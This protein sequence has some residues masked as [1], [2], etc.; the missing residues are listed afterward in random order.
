M[1][2]N[3]DKINNN[4]TE[5][6][7]LDETAKEISFALD[8]VTKSLNNPFISKVYETNQ[9]IWFSSV[10]AEEGGKK[11]MAVGI[12]SKKVSKGMIISIHNTSIY[13]GEYLV[14]ENTGSSIIFENEAITD[15]IDIEKCS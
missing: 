3:I 10:E 7:T 5:R 9:E 14:K 1:I 13:D 6:L 2:L 4:I 12:K 15:S 11:N 8:R